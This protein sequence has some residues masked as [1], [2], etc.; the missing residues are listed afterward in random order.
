M[1]KLIYIAEDDMV[2]FYFLEEVLTPLKVKIKQAKNGEELLQLIHEKVPDLVLL[3]LRMPVMSGLDAL[4]VIRKNHP[5]L[6]VV[7]QTA[8][9]MTEERERCFQ[10]GCNDYISKPIRKTAL[11]KI[12][13]PYLGLS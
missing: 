10:C 3:D 7:A 11:L 9:A 5:G 1:R 4:A 8:Y 6:P 2:S 13:E 12:V